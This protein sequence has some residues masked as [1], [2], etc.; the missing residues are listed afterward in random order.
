MGMF[1]Y[2]NFK[3]LC[4]ECGTEI[5]D[6]QSKSAGCNLVTITPI[7]AGHW[8]SYCPKCR[9]RVSYLI[10]RPPEAVF[11]TRATSGELK[12]KTVLIKEVTPS[13]W[14]EADE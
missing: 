6:W 2:V 8:Y 3:A 1:D 10:E 4:P 9:L 11:A 7:E 14:E 13:E 12:T 5:T